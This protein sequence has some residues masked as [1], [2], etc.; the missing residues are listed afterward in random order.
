[1]YNFTSQIRSYNGKIGVWCHNNIIGNIQK[2]IATYLDSMAYR[3]V[4]IEPG[5]FRSS[6]VAI[7]SFNLLQCLA[8]YAVCH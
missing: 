2:A 6:L 8:S 3:A 4:D 5:T 1:M 7:A